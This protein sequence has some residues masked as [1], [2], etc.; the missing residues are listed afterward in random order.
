MQENYLVQAF[1]FPGI[2]LLFIL[3]LPDDISKIFRL[4]HLLFLQQEPK[5]PVPIIKLFKVKLE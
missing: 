4:L 1:V 5:H 2:I 3:H